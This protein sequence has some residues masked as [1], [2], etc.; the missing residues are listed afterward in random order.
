MAAISTSVWSGHGALDPER[1]IR[2]AICVEQL[3][4]SEYLSRE[5]NYKAGQIILYLC[6]PVMW[7][8]IHIA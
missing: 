5:E 7:L 1:L 6:S 2:L 8:D 3:S 4:I